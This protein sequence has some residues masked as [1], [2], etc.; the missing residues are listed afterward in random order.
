MKG[1]P[2]DAVLSDNDEGQ[3]RTIIQWDFEFFLDVSS[4]F[5]SYSATVLNDMEYTLTIEHYL[6]I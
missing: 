2:D 1:L 3:M 5:I 6:D 4:I